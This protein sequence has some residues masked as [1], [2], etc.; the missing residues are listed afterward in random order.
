MSF[1]PS[2]KGLKVEHILKDDESLTSYLL[3][4][5]GLS[6]AVVYDLTNA[7]VRVEQV[8]YCK[9]CFLGYCF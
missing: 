1:V 9:F 8:R 3:R 6:E 2:D 7:Q 4:D 5:A